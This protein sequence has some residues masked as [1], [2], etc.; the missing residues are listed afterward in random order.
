[1]D[2]FA[3][4]DTDGLNDDEMP[5]RGSWWTGIGD[6]IHVER[7]CRNNRKRRGTVISVE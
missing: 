1:M 6:L 7:C 4:G 2:G 5:E 3:G